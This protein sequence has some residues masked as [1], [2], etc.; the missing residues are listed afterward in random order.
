MHG[1]AK[2]AGPIYLTALSA[3]LLGGLWAVR[4]A[5]RLVR[6]DLGR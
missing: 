2:A 4:R 1:P 3:M 6:R 5:L